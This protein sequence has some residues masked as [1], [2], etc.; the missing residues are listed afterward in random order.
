[1]NDPTT[2]DNGGDIDA[3]NANGENT[4]VLDQFSSARILVAIIVLVVLYVLSKWLVSQQEPN[5]R[6][7][8]IINKHDEQIS[9]IK[10][11]VIRIILI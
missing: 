11:L 7:D 4:V 1:M 10:I 6:V 2:E 8:G 9:Q 5:I 3:I